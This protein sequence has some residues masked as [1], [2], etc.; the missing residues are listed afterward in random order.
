LRN[1]SFYY[2]EINCSGVPRSKEILRN[3]PE[4]RRRKK[5]AS[6]DAE[7]L[8]QG[9][10]APPPRKSRAGFI[11]F[12]TSFSIYGMTWGSFLEKLSPQLA[13]F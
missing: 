8:I 10:A 11:L 9:A 5:I 1:V 6:E 2:S 7:G 13:D 3:G 12:E 4:Y